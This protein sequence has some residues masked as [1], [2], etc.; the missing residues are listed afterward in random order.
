[1]ILRVAILGLL[2]GSFAPAQAIRIGAAISLR[3]ALTDIAAVYETQTS[4]KVE[5]V[6]GSSGQV[7]SQIANGAPIDLFISAA[8][9]QVDQLQRQQLL[10]DQSHRIIA[11]N[12]LVLIT[13]PQA[14]SIQ[15]FSD[16]SSGT[17]R[18]A[19]GEPTTVP[20]GAYAM[21]TLTRLGL[22]EKLRGRI[23][24][25]ANVRQVLSYVERG[26]VAAGLVYRTDARQSRGQVRI[27][28]TA[29]PESHDPILYPAAIIRSSRNQEAARQFLDF[30]TTDRAR[31]ILT[32]KG[33]SMPP[34]PT[35]KPSA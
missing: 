16:L 24:Y 1:M 5:F 7:A 11:G 4:R 25:A 20:A 29:A 19:M 33:F 35:T 21:Q 32:E 31:Q 6:F 30:L 23:V 17:S 22:H 28:A 13:P 18:I 2:L 12:S 3:E 15:S 9:E 14:S 10:V 34:P 8:A 26:E 27:V